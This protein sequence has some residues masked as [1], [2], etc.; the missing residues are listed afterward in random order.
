MG[1]DVRLT[2][3]K[4][5]SDTPEAKK[6]SVARLE[7]VKLRERTA[8][9]IVLPDQVVSALD[10]DVGDEFRIEGMEDL[11]WTVEFKYAVDA[12][13]RSLRLSRHQFAS[14]HPIGLLNT[15]E[16]ERAFW[17]ARTET[18]DLPIPTCKRGIVVRAGSM[19]FVYLD[20][21]VWESGRDVVPTSIH[22]IL[23]VLY[24]DDD[25][26]QLRQREKSVSEGLEPT[27][28]RVARDTR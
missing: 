2:L 3:K 16:G 4:H 9:A 6:A 7:R 1:A 11:P 22:L 20:P 15:P 13:A 23:H 24:P 17:L 8:Y 26:D 28:D 27:P 21:E 5:P 18:P 12:V 25:E 10:L 14:T 19:H